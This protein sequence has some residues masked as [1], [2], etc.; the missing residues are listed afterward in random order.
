MPDQHSTSNLISELLYSARMCST[1]YKPLRAAQDEFF[2]FTQGCQAIHHVRADYHGAFLIEFGDRCDLVFYGRLHLPDFLAQYPHPEMVDATFG[3]C[4]LYKFFANETE[5][6]L[7]KLLAYQDVLSVPLY[8]HGHSLGGTLTTLMAMHLQLTGCTIARATV[9]GAICPGDQAVPRL[10]RSIG[11][12]NSMLKVRLAGQSGAASRDLLLKS[13]QPINKEWILGQSG[14]YLHNRNSRAS[15]GLRTSQ[16]VPDR[17][18]S[19]LDNIRQ[20]LSAFSTVNKEP[21]QQ[22]IES[23]EYLRSRLPYQISA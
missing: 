4:K 15:L 16:W 17:G 1:G 7:R 2:W 10:Q 23:L 8:L 14:L 3:P 12:E 18:S 13:I 19:V 20:T 22:Y 9:F 6:I 21:V 11:L 5:L